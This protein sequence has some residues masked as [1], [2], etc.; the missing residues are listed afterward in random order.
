MQAFFSYFS[1]INIII[2]ILLLVRLYLGW[3]WFA[4]GLTKV[5]SG[6][7]DAS[8][9]LQGAIA[10][11][12]TAGAGPDIA[13]PWYVSFLEYIALPQSELFSFVVMW[14][15][16]LVGL[17]LIIGCLTATAALFGGLMNMSFLLAGT[18]STNPILL[19]LS[20]VVILG[21]K[22]AGTLGVDGF[23]MYKNAQ[24]QKK[25]V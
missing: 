12:V 1:R 22:H 23:L 8:G 3:Q 24:Q 11:P 7:F 10:Q 17:G 18:V 16:V 14:G 5:T 4:S 9:Y 25:S 2:S 15:E 6:T 20:F 19:L 13:Y 21:R